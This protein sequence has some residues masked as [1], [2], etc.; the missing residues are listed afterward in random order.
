MPLPIYVAIQAILTMVA[1]FTAVKIYRSEPLH[2][3]QRPSFQYYQQTR[4]KTRDAYNRRIG[5]VKKIP[6]HSRL[7]SNKELDATPKTDETGEQTAPWYTLG[8]A[9]AKAKTAARRNTPIVSKPYPAT[10]TP[11]HERQGWLASTV[12]TL[13][14]G[15]F[16]SDSTSADGAD[17]KSDAT[18]Y[19]H[20]S[21]SLFI[22]LIR[23]PDCDMM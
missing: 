19:S 10:I 13:P 7:R 21:T 22:V 23:A 11:S 12:D 14:H 2:Y 8:L 9:E 5:G 16:T 17:P 3:R 20:T 6:P 18:L 4:K 1:V 15:D